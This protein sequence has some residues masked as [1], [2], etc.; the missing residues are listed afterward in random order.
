MDSLRSHRATSISQ[1]L[2]GHAGG[3]HLAQGGL[4]AKQGAARAGG[5]RVQEADGCH[6]QIV[7]HSHMLSA[8]RHLAT[9]PTS[10]GA[11]NKSSQAQAGALKAPQPVQQ[12]KGCRAACT[13][14]PAH[15]SSTSAW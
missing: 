7:L 6:G 12:Q 13:C 10:T 11:L 8:L 3:T 9:I 5:N 15:A 4:A 1:A 14:L 2:Q